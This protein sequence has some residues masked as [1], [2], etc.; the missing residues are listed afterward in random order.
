MYRRKIITF[1]FDFVKKSID[2]CTRG[3][4]YNN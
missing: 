2:I 1:L 3:V 4:Y